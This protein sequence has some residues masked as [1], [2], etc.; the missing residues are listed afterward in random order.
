M[1]ELLRD[2]VAVL[3]VLISFIVVGVDVCSLHL[4]HYVQSWVEFSCGLVSACV[5]F[6]VKVAFGVEL[7]LRVR[8]DAQVCPAGGA[9]AVRDE[10]LVL[11][12]CGS[13][14]VEVCL[15]RNAGDEFVCLFAAQWWFAF[16]YED[17]VWLSVV[18]LVMGGTLKC[19]GGGGRWYVEAPGAVWCVPVCV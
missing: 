13:G 18:V 1:S 8:C 17:E 10:R 16:G 3:R 5:G 9:R 14:M 19:L 6:S 2:V 7:W 11:W 15:D 12:Y 4:V